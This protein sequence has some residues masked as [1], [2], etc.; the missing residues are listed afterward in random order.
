[1]G[2]IAVDTTFLIDWQREVAKGD[3]PVDRFLQLHSADHFS[4]CVT[5]LGEFSS[6]FADLGVPYFRKVK[7][8]FR[9]RPIDEETAMVY[10]IIYRELKDSGTLIGA[11]DLWI[12]AAALQHNLPL[13]TRNVR[14]FQ[15]V[16]NLRILCY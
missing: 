14:E 9:L 11:N 8:A 10:R 1:M 7:S 2:E 15:R 5:V 16:S 6:G 3:G 13:V 4:M 12:A